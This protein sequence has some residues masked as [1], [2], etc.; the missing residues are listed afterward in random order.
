MLFA[1]PS[2]LWLLALAVP[3][4]AAHLR[5]RGIATSARRIWVVSTRLLAFTAL[6]L[7]LARP[8]IERQHASSTTVVIADISA[9][10]SDADLVSEQ[11]AIERVIRELQPG[12]TLRLVAF[13]SRAREIMLSRN[14]IERD[15]LSRLR[16]GNKHAQPA[17]GSVLADAMNLAGALI[18]DDAGRIIILSDGLQTAGDARTAAYRLGQSRIDVETVAIGEP[19]QQGAALRALRLPPFV[20]AGTTVSLEAEVVAP[21]ATSTQV[22]IRKEGK[23]I[24]NRQEHLDPGRNVIRELITFDTPG[25]STCSVEIGGARDPE[26]ASLSASVQVGP[27]RTV[28]VIEDAASHPAAIALGAMLRSSALVRSSAPSELS[29]ASTLNDCDLLVIADTPAAALPLD[30]QQRI[31]SAVTSGMGLLVTGGRRSFGPGGYFGTPVA[32]VLP[33]RFPQE[34]ERREPSTSLVIIIDTSGS[35]GGPRVSLAKEI[36]RLALARLGPHDKAG[37]VEFYGSKRWAAPIQPASNA[38]DLQRALNRLNASGGTVILPAIEEAYYAL[39]NVRTRTKHV[40]VLTDGGVETGAFEPLIRKMADHEIAVSTVM[41]GPGAH[42]TFLASLAQWGHGR[43]YAAPDRFNL[44]EVIVKQP[45]SSPIAPFVEQSSQIVPA[46]NVPLLR[47]IDFA[48]APNL[49]GYVKTEARPTADVWLNT[50]QGDPLLARWRYGLGAVAVFTS[51]LSGEWSADAARW[52]EY[53]QLM[54]GVVRSLYGVRPD[55]ALQIRPTCR[56]GGTEIDIVNALPGEGLAS[57]AIELAVTDTADTT[58]RWILDP[59]L[60]GRWNLLLQDLSPGTYRLQAHVPG[61]PRAGSAAITV[62]PEREFTDIGP[63]RELLDQMTTA[64]QEGK[65]NSSPYPVVTRRSTELWP[66]LIGVGIVLFLLNVLAR[67]W[68]GRNTV[69]QHGPSGGVL[70]LVLIVL[71]TWSLTAV[72]AIAASTTSSTPTTEPGDA[73]SWAEQAR[74]EEISGHDAAALRSLDRAIQL[75]HEAVE[76]AELALRKAAILYDNGRGSEAAASLRA[77]GNRTQAGH[78]AGL[79]GDYATAVE[80]LQPTGTPAEQMRTHLFRGLFLLHLDRTQEAQSEYEQALALAATPRDRKFAIERI[81]TAARRGHRL[82]AL[83]DHWLAAKGLPPDQLVAVLIVLRELGRTQETLPLLQG[84]PDGPNAAQLL[85]SPDFRREAVAAALASGRPAEAEGIY[86]HLLEHEPDR[87]ELLVSLARLHLADGDARAAD[88]LLR[89]ALERWSDALRLF[90]LAEGARSLSLDDTALAAARRAGTQSPA[91]RVRAILFEAGLLRER[92]QADAAVQMLHDAARGEQKPESLQTLADALERFGDK[93][94]ALA[95]YQRIYEHTYTED[96]LLRLAW[97]MEDNQKLPEA[98]ALW[99][100]LW[101][102]T[103]VD[104]RLQQAKQRVLDLASRT[105]TLADLAIEIEERI[106]KGEPSD[107]ELS[108][109]LDIYTTA[110]DPVSAAEILQELAQRGGGQVQMLQRLARVYLSCEQ[111]GRCVTVL[112]QLVKLDPANA[113]DYLQ[114]LAILA[115]ERKQPHEARRV[116]AELREAAGASPVSDEISAGVL[117]MLDLHAEAARCYERALDAHPD[118]VELLL[119]W[120]R[121]AKAAGEGDLAIRRFQHVVESAAEDDLFTVAVDGLL[122]LQAP[123]NVARWALR[124]IYLRITANPEKVFLYQLAA[125]LLELADPTQRNSGLL[126]QAVVVAGERRGALIRELMDD[127]RSQ[128]QPARQIEHGHTLLLLGDELPPQVFVE[129]GEALIKQGQLAAAEQVFDRAGVEADY[130]AIRQKMASCYEDAG[131]PADAER[132]LRELVAT[133]RDNL[134][135]LMR[136]AAV[137]EQLGQFEPAFQAY[138]HVVDLLLR[139]QPGVV[140]S[141]SAP[142]DDSSQQA[143]PGRMLRRSG[144]GANLDEMGQYL[145]PAMAGLLG[146]VRLEAT[147]ERLVADL[148]ER[149]RKELHALESNSQLQPR[150]AENPR[151]D[152]LAQ[153]LRR[154]AFALH[155]PDVADAIDRDLIAQYPQDKALP[156]S[157]AQV[158]RDW[159]LEVRAA[160]FADPSAEPT[161]RPAPIE[162]ANRVPSNRIDD[163]RRLLEQSRPEDRVELLRTMVA[164]RKSAEQ[165]TFIMS[166]AGCWSWPSDGQD[167]EAIAALFQ[168]APKIKTESGGNYY[169]LSQWDWN[170]NDLQ[171]ELGRQIGEILLGEAPNDVST[172]IAVAVARETAGRHDEAVPLVREAIEGLLAVRTVDFQHKRMVDDAGRVLGPVELDSI[173]TD[174][175]DR[176]AIEG[177]TPMLLLIRGLLLQAADRRADAVTALRSAFESAPTNHALSR[178]FITACQQD[179]R[180]VELSRSLAANLTSSAVTESYEWRTLTEA[181][182]DLFDP[183]ASV[184]AARRDESPLGPVY[185]LWAA[186][187]IAQP[188]ETLTALRRMMCR[189]RESGRVY[190]PFWPAETTLGGLVGFRETARA[191][192]VR[193]GLFEALADLPFARDEYQALLCGAAPNRND[194]KGLV[195]GLRQAIVSQ[196][197]RR[198]A[199]A[200]LVALDRRDALTVTDRALLIAL[201]ADVPEDLPED[202]GPTIDR[203]LAQ[204][205]AASSSLSKPDDADL[206]DLNEVVTS[207]ASDENARR[208]VAICRRISTT[209]PVID[210]RGALETASEHVDPS[211]RIDVILGIIETAGQRRAITPPVAVRSRCL[212]A[213]WCAEH[214]LAAKGN[215]I[216]NGCREHAGEPGEHYLW[217]ADAARALKDEQQAIELEGTLLAASMLPIARVPHYLDAIEA[218]AGRNAADDLALSLTNYTSHP[219]ILERAIRAALR[220]GDNVA[221]DRCRRRLPAT[222]PA[223][224][225]QSAPS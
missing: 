119:L 131:H 8:I 219:V 220:K 117:E 210:A 207:P 34:L 173:L 86:R 21:A 70:P 145:E 153:L 157:C 194:V 61:G 100:K 79:A 215:S 160:A 96:V 195:A 211:Q 214:Q 110:N 122:N 185:S 148:A 151:L 85:D 177:V 223:S 133:D 15:L 175:Q 205:D 92:G 149:V 193:R 166:L 198:S 181:Y 191:P 55:N 63:D 28:W 168:T 4:A 93:A 146:S 12:A 108:M 216:L 41:V 69:H 39:Q 224:S 42:S 112:R 162:V 90:A 184:A 183:A 127:A 142:G 114:Q 35:M 179:G 150:L 99:K 116:L 64:N 7:A 165:R 154:T 5:S 87:V 121:A 164:S 130:T 105:G 163:V 225:T 77:S 30:A 71:S 68:P 23:I 94:E 176:E 36:A 123:P 202:A 38:I 80:L 189:N 89:A 120:G 44:P 132:I 201:A 143:R 17:R 196:G 128:G 84:L 138:G 57:A 74:D 73:H 208:A 161:S 156:A 125:D 46:G 144:E 180:L 54:A 31:R 102:T 20:D 13:D 140:E 171:P 103:Q 88:Q 18:R 200:E 16:E 218:K 10:I 199:L 62:P 134:A 72:P 98:L 60:A 111:F 113:T 56:P 221:A 203:I 136:A 11:H 48:A 152:R 26:E 197:T 67:R 25:L 37:I 83:A 141:A 19:A 14:A 58:R 159:G 49:A 51:Q 109:L 135:L 115:V 206:A 66:P 190:T 188:A 137:N 76:G 212:L 106:S 107:R 22:V 217:M 53:G 43:F 170:R 78:L 118:R 139:R 32:D 204:A 97:L 178:T 155:D 52:S 147:R 172:L 129:L 186:R 33:V 75:Q 50:N 126:E 124:R 182:H 174:L 47:G 40:L 169:G 29:G 24:A 27:P 2:W 91:D 45:E 82:N 81:V 192:V 95:L 209:E 59:V 9:S 101:V 6:V 65:R 213:A 3:V 222:Q 167:I 158:R 187:P 104:A 1:H